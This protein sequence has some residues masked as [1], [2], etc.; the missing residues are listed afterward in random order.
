M[1]KIIIQ[2]STS[3]LPAATARRGRPRVKNSRYEVAYNLTAQQKAVGIQKIRRGAEK[4]A[5]SANLFLIVLIVIVI[6]T[7]K[8]RSLSYR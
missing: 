5:C 1:E 2:F 3:L 8:I 7:V 4:V 6:S